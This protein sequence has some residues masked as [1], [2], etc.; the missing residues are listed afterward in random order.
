MGGCSLYQKGTRR[1]CTDI[2]WPM[3]RFLNPGA[4]PTRTLVESCPPVPSLQ[5]LTPSAVNQS[6]FVSSSPPI[7]LLVLVFFPT[8]S[9]SSSFALHLL[10]PSYS[11]PRLVSRLPCP[12]LLFLLQPPHPLLTWLLILV[13]SKFE[14]GC[15]LFH[16]VWAP[17]AG[18]SRAQ[19]STTTGSCR[20]VQ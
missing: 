14:S 16:N 17:T 4:H 9:Q 12:S 5:N 3:L 19:E 1:L 8:K 2:Y 7:R 20:E 11:T 13:L 10:C 6:C 18:V 15:F